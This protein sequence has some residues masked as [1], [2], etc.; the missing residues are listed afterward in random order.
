MQRIRA[1][2]AAAM[3]GVSP[4][5]VQ[6]M[7]ARG[8]LPSAAKIGKVWTFDPATLSRWISDREADVW[9]RKTACAMRDKARHM[10]PSH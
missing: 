9:L 1:P 4:R 8:D 10:L 3:L 2:A 5:S 6:A 7:A